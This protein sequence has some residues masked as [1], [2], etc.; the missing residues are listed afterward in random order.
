MKPS[1]FIGSSGLKYDI[2]EAIA[3]RLSDEIDTHPWR[4][5]FPVGK[6]TLRALVEEAVRVD[7]GIFVFGA[8]DKLDV[9]ISVPRDN[10]IYEAG[11]FAGVLGTDRSL[12]VHQK[13]VKMPSDLKGMTVAKFDG[14]NSATKVANAVC[15]VLLKAMGDNRAKRFKTVAGTI[16]GNWWQFSMAPEG[17]EERAKVSL[18]R[19]SRIPSGYLKFEGDAWTESGERLA[20]FESDLSSVNE[21][22]LAYRYNWTGKWFVNK[23]KISAEPDAFYGKGKFTLSRGNLDRAHGEYTTRNDTNRDLDDLTPVEYCRAAAQDS[24]HMDENSDLSVR[25]NVIRARLAEYLAAR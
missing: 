4:T 18:M 16:E 23:K 20:H 11:L 25:R 15:P 2:V 24:K 9:K 19:F 10:V 5:A 1:A 21:N 3:E 14:R 22:D 6:M 13:N 7:F 8:D 17:G 12:I